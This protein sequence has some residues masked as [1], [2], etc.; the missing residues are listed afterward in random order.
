MSA[1]LNPPPKN[2]GPIEY[3]SI[4]AESFPFPNAIR[5]IQ[6]VSAGSG[7]LVVKDERG[8]ARTYTAL[9]AGDV[10][11][12]P[13]TELTSMTCTKIRAGDGD[14]PAPNSAVAV[15]S[16]FTDATSTLGMISFAPPDFALATGAPLAIFANGASAV[17]GLW[18]AES[19]ALGVRWNDNAT[20]NGIVA[21]CMIPPDMDVTA[22]AVLHI[23]AAKVGATLADAVTFL[24]TAFNQPVG[25]T[26]IADA[27]FGGTTSAM[28]GDAASKTVQDV[29]L[30]LA[31]ANL[32]AYPASMT[33]TIAPTAGI[34]SADDVIILSAFILYTKKLLPAS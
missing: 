22:N 20:S 4:A 27:D 19:E 17:P 11:V 16:L 12:G 31:L 13:F 10:L 7:G 14:P 33:F 15:A 34:L 18:N 3:T 28:T 2:R 5:W 32:A 30:T 26:Y 8:T 25:S 21:S 23:H 9:V 24:V 29:T 6:V 1:V